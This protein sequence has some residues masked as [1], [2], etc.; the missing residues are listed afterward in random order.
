MQDFIIVLKNLFLFNPTAQ[1]SF[2]SAYFLFAFTIL[3]LIYSFVSNNLQARKW[4]LIVF[5]FFFYY[6]LTGL[7]SLIILAPVIVDFY[8][9]KAI[10]STESERRKKL[11]MYLSI[12]CSLGLLVYFKYTNFFLVI[13]NAISGNSVSLL[14]IIVPIGISF[15]VFRSIS[16]IQDVYN[17]KIDP[18]KNFNDYLLYM[19]FFPLLISGPITRAELFAPQIEDKNLVTK[20]KIQ[21]G[22]FLIFKGIIKKA[23]FADYLSLYVAM[24]FN[25]PEGYTGLE[26]LVG[27]IC[28]TI[29]L[30]LDFSGYTDIAVGISRILGFDIGINFNEPLK[31][32]SISDFW[33]RWHI[34]L[35]EWLRDYLYF[36][37][38]YYFRKLKTFGAILAMFITFFICGIWHGTTILFILFGLMHGLALSWEI[39][40][41]KYKTENKIIK[42]IAPSLGWL[43]TF[44]FIVVTFIS[45]RADNLNSAL[46]ILTG[47]FT[48]MDYSKAILFITVQ[49]MF[50]A[51]LITA[52]ALIFAPTFLKEKFK[53][54]F[55][56][57]PLLIK[58]AFFI[59]IVQIIVE[60]ENQNI[61]PF[62]YAQY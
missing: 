20:D 28:F 22:L 57:T 60:M 12:F 41:R 53:G 52:I 37:L 50:T 43:M 59:V 42:A 16:Y 18:V 58:V 25:T 38:N 6:K 49:G 40:I 13:V 32:R 55:L 54:L 30:Y 11:F 56:K 39:F 27:I 8:C 14:K 61:V 45:M 44:C 62:I 29:Q 46:G 21:E 9:A 5:N 10:F 24:I 17:E 48:K 33:R 15:Y 34:S 26:N 31:S 7:L 36:P 47:I 23:I 3:V 35:S 2:I 4:L 1:I 19:T 51:M